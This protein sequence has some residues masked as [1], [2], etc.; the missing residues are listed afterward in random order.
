MKRETA[1][2]KDQDLNA[3]ESVS[4]DGER[5]PLPGKDD[6]AAENRR[7]ETL[8]AEQRARGREIVVVMEG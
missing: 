3:L 7:L 4:P 6:Y 8:V 1:E 5:F 2:I